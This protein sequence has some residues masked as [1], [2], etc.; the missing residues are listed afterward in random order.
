MIRLIGIAG[1]LRKQSFNVALLKAAA[2]AAP[3]DVEFE[4]RS[5]DGFPL[6][7]EDIETSD[8]VPK[9]VAELKDAIAASAGLVITTPEYNAGI[10]G[11]MKNAIDWLSR[12]MSDQARVL[13]GKS[14]ALMGATPGGFGTTFAQTAWLPVLRTLRMKL[15][16]EQGALYVSGASTVFDE[17]GGLTDDDVRS[18]LENYLRGFVESLK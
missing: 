14:V 13:Y 2:A 1:S 15:W 16:V 9:A 8:G 4:I 5:I 11:V 3:P 12:P 6:Y 17:D 7:N 10:P 18:R